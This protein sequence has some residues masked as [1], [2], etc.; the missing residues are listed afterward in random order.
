MGCYFSSTLVLA[1]MNQIIVAFV[2]SFFVKM[3]QQMN[4]RS[5]MMDLSSAPTVT[6][7]AG[8]QSSSLGALIGFIYLNLINFSSM[9]SVYLFLATIYS[10]VILLLISS[11][12]S[13]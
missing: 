13:L 2:R 9:A 11:S 3:D 6:S 8:V 12:G 5:L 1:N 4:I 7:A 10:E